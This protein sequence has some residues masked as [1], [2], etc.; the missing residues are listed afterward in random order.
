MGQKKLTMLVLIDLS[1][2][3]DTVNHSMLLAQ[4][5]ACFGVAG[6]VLEWFHS[7]LIN[8]KQSVF[9]HGVC[10]MDCGVPQGSCCGP[11]LFL[12]YT[13]SLFDVEACCLPKCSEYADDHGF[14]LSFNPDSSDGETDAIAD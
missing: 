4:L 3:F 8:R 10:S 6:G 1:A 11:Y 2:A 5:N 14:Y 9:I 13:S 7:Y 12:W